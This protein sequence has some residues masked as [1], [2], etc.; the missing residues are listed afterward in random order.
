MDHSYVAEHGLIEL[1]HQGLLDPDEEA[2]FEEHFVAC[3][4]CTEQ[5]ELARGLSRGIKAMVAE[6]AARTVVAGGLLAWL[7]RRGR[8]IQL[9]LAA[10]LLLLAG[11][12]ALWLWREGRRQIAV[13]Q[14]RAQDNEERAAALEEQLAE[15]ERL[16]E[17]ERRTA[18]EKLAEA[19]R[20]AP[21]VGVPVY[22]LTVVRGEPDE[23]RRIDA[24]DRFSL[25][26]D[27]GADPRFTSYR[28]TI[29][30][31]AG[32]RVLAQAG[33]H[34]NALEVLMITFPGDFFAPGSYRLRVEGVLADGKKE[35]IG[36]YA[37]R[38]VRPPLGEVRAGRG[39]LR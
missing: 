38:V 27:V 6:D 5:L 8:L 4:E 3:A 17:Q 33:L 15:S 20:E 19:P 26:V 36:T 30:D 25:A 10:A 16:R 13:E 11:L 21:W 32:R 24:K 9:G 28:V 2:R 1:Y 35:S 39:R 22:L 37:F 7:A 12:P 23:V 18:T 34:P 31:A 14:E 29:E